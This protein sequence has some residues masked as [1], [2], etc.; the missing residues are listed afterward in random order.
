M[1]WGPFGLKTTRT[2]TSI[3]RG[4]GYE[5]PFSSA[6]HRGIPYQWGEKRAPGLALRAHPC[7]GCCAQNGKCYLL[8]EFREGCALIWEG[9][10]IHNVPVKYIELVISHDILGSHKRATG[11]RHMPPYHTMTAQPAC[12][13]T[14]FCQSA[15]PVGTRAPPG[16]SLSTLILN[17]FQS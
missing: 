15:L 3:S 7:L 5:A 11:F 9:G 13:R 1:A 10:V 17:M 8:A 16:Y 4:Q 6:G 14:P 12:L 2:Q